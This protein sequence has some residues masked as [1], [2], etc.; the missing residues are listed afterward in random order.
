MCLLLLA[1]IHQLVNLQSC[2]FELWYILGAVKLAV[3]VHNLREAFLR[4]YLL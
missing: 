2:W 1:L 3:L 4:Y